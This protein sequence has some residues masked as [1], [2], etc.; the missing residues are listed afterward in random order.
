M[1]KPAV[2]ITLS[3][4]GLIL[5]TVA[6]LFELFV[7]FIFSSLTLITFGPFIIVHSLALFVL[8]L[9]VIIIGTAGIY[10]MS[11]GYKGD[12]FVGSLLEIVA[13]IFAYPTLFGFFIGSF[14]MFSGGI[15]GLFWAPLKDV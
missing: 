8:G 11:K 3:M 7:A 5:Q 9:I 4:I 2:A 10:F 12:V 6:L 1:N 14:L 13:S 15:I